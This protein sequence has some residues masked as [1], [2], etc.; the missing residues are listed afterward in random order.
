MTSTEFPTQ[1]DLGRKLYAQFN[2]DLAEAQENIALTLRYIHD[3][4]PV[5]HLVSADALRFELNN[6]VYLCT[7]AYPAGWWIHPW[8]LDQMLQAVGLRKDYIQDLL[9][10]KD[11]WGRALAVYTLN[12][13]FHA[14]TEQYLLRTVGQDLRGFLS[15]RYQRR[16]AGLVVDG[17][18]RACDQADLR[19]VFAWWDVLGHG[20]Y[21]CH[22][23]L[24]SAGQDEAVALGLYYGDSP[25][26][27]Q[28]PEVSL[29][30]Q[31]V[32]SG[33]WILLEQSLRQTHTGSLPDDLS[34]SP[35]T[36]DA[37]TQ[38]MINK[39]K[40]L[41]AVGA[42]TST[43]PRLLSQVA[44]AEQRTLDM[45]RFQRFLTENVSRAEAVEIMEVYRTGGV[46][47]L[48][49]GDTY[50]RGACAVAAYAHNPTFA[51]SRRLSFQKIAG[52]LL[53]K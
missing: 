13:F 33:H 16:H 26:G 5:D 2:K 9:H 8:A 35:E 21:S 52:K 28:P 32:P 17:F 6:D 43:I 4:T 25:Y 20:V 10:K 47:L 1:T 49:L 46:S 36:A 51:M 29:A 41:V 50:W 53:T 34:W 18:R 14:R 3:Q 42:R 45:D 31:R 12:H 24:Y 19:T 22:P 40:D 38:L 30:I 23:K 44:K 39:I 37:D 11:A 48:P 27:C 7:G 15:P